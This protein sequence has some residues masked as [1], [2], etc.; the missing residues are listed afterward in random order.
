[1]AEIKVLSSVEKE[2]KFK[3]PM[4]ALEV[5]C[6]NETRKVNVFSNAL[7]FANIKQGYTINGTMEKKGEYWDIIF[8]GAQKPRA[9]AYKAVQK[10]DIAEAQAVKAK[11]IAEAQDRTAWMWAKNNATDIITSTNLRDGETSNAEEMVDN[12]IKLATKIYNAE[13][14]EP[15]N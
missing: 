15:F 3:K 5:F 7:D 1:M 4:K 10:A 12:I 2:T 11:N 13:P 9:G 8:D 14:T 6:E